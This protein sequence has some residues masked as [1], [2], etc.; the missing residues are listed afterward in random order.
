MRF[1][2]KI[3]IHIK[4]VQ[5]RIFRGKK[6]WRGSGKAGGLYQAMEQT[7][8]A[9][10]WVWIPINYRFWINTILDFRLTT[11]PHHSTIMAIYSFPSNINTVR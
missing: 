4:V 10:L 8:I 11:D 5:I 3:T 6:V 9:T 2:S 7:I 1:P